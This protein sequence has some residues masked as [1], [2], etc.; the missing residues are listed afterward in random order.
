MAAIRLCED[1]AV[2]RHESRRSR[3]PVVWPEQER[4][5]VAAIV[6]GLGRI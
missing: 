2:Y 4:D 6:S 3:A 1:R 5:V